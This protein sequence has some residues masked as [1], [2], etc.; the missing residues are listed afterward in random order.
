LHFEVLVEGVPQNPARFLAGRAGDPRA[1]A[2]SRRS[3]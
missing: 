3:R 1:L 2:A